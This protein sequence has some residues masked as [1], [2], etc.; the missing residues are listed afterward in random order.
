MYLLTETVIKGISCLSF[1]R[2]WPSVCQP[3]CRG[4]AAF[5]GYLHFIIAST[6]QRI[7]C[8]VLV[9]YSREFYGSPGT[10]A[11]PVLP[12]HFPHLGPSP[13]GN[14]PSRC[15]SQW[16]QRCCPTFG[17]DCPAL[18]EAFCPAPSV[19]QLWSVSL[20]PPTENSISKETVVFIK[21]QTFYPILCG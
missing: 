11:V 15:D 9:L 20:P 3:L 12:P 8:P 1:W 17:R 19:G 6:T 4:L 2:C 21:K 10:E 13:H 14:V 7:L 5:Q 18:G 16:Q